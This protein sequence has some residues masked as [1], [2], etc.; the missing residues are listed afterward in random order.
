[1]QG[2]RRGNHVTIFFTFKNL[3]EGLVGELRPLPAG[4]FLNGYKAGPYCMRPARLFTRPSACATPCLV[5]TIP[6]RVLYQGTTIISSRDIPSSF[7]SSARWRAS[8]QCCGACECGT[9][10]TRS[11]SID[12]ACRQ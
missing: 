11:L 10:C 3:R 8:S 5:G 12:G 2:L 9:T 4:L 1:M 6:T 7:G